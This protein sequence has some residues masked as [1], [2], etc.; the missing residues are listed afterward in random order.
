MK[1]IYA[2]IIAMLLLFSATL[3]VGCN[4]KTEEKGQELSY[5]KK[6]IYKFKIN[7]DE[8]EQEYYIF[9]QNGTGQYHYYGTDYKYVFN[10]TLYTYEYFLA[11]YIINFIY[12]L[13]S[14]TVVCF[15]DSIIYDEVN[16]YQSYRGDWNPI[17]AF[18]KNILI[19]VDAN[20]TMYICEDYVPNIPNY[21]K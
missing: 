7:S 21:F 16:E 1:K 14:D 4:N 17:L 2:V 11:S 18:S 15:Y 10:G 8:I 6:Y 12:E 5:S 20:S 19:A 9:N 13:I 3:F